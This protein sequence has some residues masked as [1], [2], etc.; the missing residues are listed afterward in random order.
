[1]RYVAFLD[2]LG[3]KSKLKNYNHD[4][5]VRFIKMFASTV[6][7]KF[8]LL[9]NS[10]NI[11]GYLVS[12]SLI[13][14]ST[15]NK[16]E[17]LVALIDLIDDISKSLFT[18]NGIFI[19]GGIARGNFDKVPASPIESLEKGLIVGQAYVKAFK[20]EGVAHVIGT[21]VSKE[22]SDDILKFNIMKKRLVKVD[23]NMIAPVTDDGSNESGDYYLLNYLN[24]DFLLGKDNLSKFIYNAIKYKKVPHYENTL[25]LSIRNESKRKVEALKMKLNDNDFD[26]VDRSN[27]TSFLEKVWRTIE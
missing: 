18:D 14:Y 24:I 2:I 27:L 21:I 20:L 15:D 16:K 8:K 5:A 4:E 23:K 13:L 22:V 10:N 7:N 19:R 17:S 3:F 26:N 11:K 25:I 1:M 9:K 6:Y 12:D